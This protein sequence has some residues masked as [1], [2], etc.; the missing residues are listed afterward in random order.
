M[1]RFGNP[2]ISIADKVPDKLIFCEYNPD[3]YTRSLNLGLIST[4][5]DEKIGLVWLIL[6]F[7]INILADEILV[8]EH[9]GCG[10]FWSRNFSVRELFSDRMF[11]SHKVLI[12]L[13][14]RSQI[15]WSQ[16]HP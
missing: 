6:I 8:K 4:S 11:W 5:S 9:F 14:F 3:F 2:S 12:T 15:S 7:V 10:T 16:S 1:K 13:K